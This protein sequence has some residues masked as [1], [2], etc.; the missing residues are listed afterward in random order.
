MTIRRARHRSADF[1]RISARR[2][3]PAYRLSSIR[4][5]LTTILRAFWKRK[6]GRAPLPPCS[7]VLRLDANSPVVRWHLAISFHLRAS[8]PSR[9][10][11]IYAQS[12]RNCRRIA[13]WS[14]PTRLIWRLANI[15]ANETNQPSWSKPQKCSP[16]S[17]AYHLI[18][19][20]RRAPPISIACLP[21]YLA[22]RSC[23]RQRVS[24]RRRRSDDAKFH[25]SWLWFVGWRA[26]ASFGL[27]SLRP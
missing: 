15:A 27:G 4:V 14:R 11:S 13:F 19:S 10:L 9:T 22:R 12:R 8:S 17:A 25:N 6:P 1:A 20:P 18:R 2:E 21:R 7:I 16:R 5:M 23:N 3:K 26:T 24:K